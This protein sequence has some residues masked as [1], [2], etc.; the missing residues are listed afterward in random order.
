MQVGDRIY[1]A[2]RRFSKYDV[3]DLK[4]R[5]VAENYFVGSEKDTKQA[6]LFH[7]SD[8][9]DVVFTH[10]SDALKEAKEREK[11]MIKRVYTETDYEEY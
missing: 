4:V 7:Y 5:T 1:Y 8:L 2:R 3:I 11:H 6:F 10:R 9:D